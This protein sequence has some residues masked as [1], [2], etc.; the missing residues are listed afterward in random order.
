MR[1]LIIEDDIELSHVMKSGLEKDQVQ[2]C[3]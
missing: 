3:V 2:I 1:L